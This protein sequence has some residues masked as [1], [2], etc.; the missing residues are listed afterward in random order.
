MSTVKKMALVF[1]SFY[2]VC[3]GEKLERGNNA[4]DAITQANYIIFS[5]STLQEGRFINRALIVRKD[6]S[7]QH[8]TNFFKQR[9][10][11]FL[12]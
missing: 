9:T 3:F 7:V 8:W 1:F 5:S 4:L 11:D 6:L 10:V 2:C 12:A